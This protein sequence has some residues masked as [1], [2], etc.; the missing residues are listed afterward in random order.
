MNGDK[1]KDRVFISIIGY[2]DNGVFEIGTDFLSK[3]AENPLRVESGKQKVSDGNGG[4]IEID[5]QTP[6][7]IE[8]VSNG[9]CPMGEAFEFAKKLIVG[10]MYRK[11]DCPPPVIINLSDGIPFPYGEKQKTIFVTKEIMELSCQDGFP[12][13]FNFH[14]G[15]GMIESQFC[16]SESEL[17]DEQAKFLFSISSKIPDIYKYQ[18]SLFGK[19]TGT[20]S[21]GF[22]SNAYDL[23]I[24]CL[25]FHFGS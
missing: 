8:P 25:V 20:D 4:L 23:N 18:L 17:L 13:I 6:I 15:D 1:V 5:V 10:W 7:W 12:L 24:L 16:E 22:V 9:F 11:A 21:R 2:G 3:Y 19:I 14:I